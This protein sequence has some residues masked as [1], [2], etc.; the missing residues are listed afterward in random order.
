VVAQDLAAWPIV[1]G[2]VAP[3][4]QLW[5][6][7][8]PTGT[9]AMPS[10]PDWAHPTPSP[11]LMVRMPDPKAW[12]APHFGSMM[13]GKA[14]T[15]HAQPE[16]N[17]ES[18]RA[19]L[20]QVCVPF[21]QG[22][23][24]AVEQLVEKEVERQVKQLRQQDQLSAMHWPHRRLSREQQQQ[25]QQQHLQQAQLQAQQQQRAG[26]G[27]TCENMPFGTVFESI[28]GGQGEADS[29]RGNVAAVPL[30]EESSEDEAEAEGEQRGQ[31]QVLFGGKVPASCSR[32]SSRSGRSTSSEDPKPPGFGAS[33]MG[34]R[35]AQGEGDPLY[36]QWSSQ[37]QTVGERPALTPTVS[38]VPP[39]LAP[40]IQG[41]NASNSAVPMDGSQSPESPAGQAKSAVVCR[42]WKSKGWCRLGD[43]CK[44][45][46]PE[47]KCGAGLTKKADKEKGPPGSRADDG[48]NQ[49]K[50]EKLDKPKGKK[51]S[52]DIGSK[53]VPRTSPALTPGLVNPN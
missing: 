15:Q 19:L 37:G 45:A 22:M 13:N 50:K 21:V 41:M 10:V 14:M 48:P 43:E 6:M 29:M 25:Q 44:F 39:H 53:E 30:P 5:L 34:Q 17:S 49:D 33:A 7:S 27:N 11:S 12:Q 40:S 42:H 32:S 46:H 18:L 31:F 16:Q 35:A 24:N 2:P 52:K 3:G 26:F 47:H 28:G 8:S 1:L 4:E 51:K 23:L 38:P 36:L 20:S 9:P